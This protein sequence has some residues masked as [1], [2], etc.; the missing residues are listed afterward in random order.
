MG[1]PG[2]P[3]Q[4]P[5]ADVHSAGIGRVFREPAHCTE[6]SAGQVGRPGLRA[7]RPDLGGSPT[8]VEMAGA[9]APGRGPA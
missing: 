6:V 3:H 4:P 1:S 7:P 8:G 9:E 5:R 2:P